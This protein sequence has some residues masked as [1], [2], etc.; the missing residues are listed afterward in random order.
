MIFKKKTKKQKSEKL[1]N[2]DFE[3]QKFAKI[4]VKQRFPFTPILKPKPG[5]KF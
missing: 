5:L 4:T 2:F 3:N 1:K